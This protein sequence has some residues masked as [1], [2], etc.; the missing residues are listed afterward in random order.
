MLMF[1]MFNIFKKDKNKA[2]KD[3]ILKKYFNSKSEKKAIVHAARES[4]REQNE[5]LTKYR[6][7]VRP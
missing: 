4:S 6:Q 3:L 5:L 1:A 2:V 7:L